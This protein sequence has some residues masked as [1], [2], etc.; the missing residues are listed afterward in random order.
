MLRDE[1]LSKHKINPNKACVSVTETRIKTSDHVTSIFYKHK[2]LIRKLQSHLH[3][4][5]YVN[6]S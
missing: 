4:C 1:E 3:N 5:V 2:R 6:S